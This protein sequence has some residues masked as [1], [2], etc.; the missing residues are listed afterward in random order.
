MSLSSYPSS[1]LSVQPP[2]SGGA[3]FS[4][5]SLF[6]VELPPDFP[7]SELPKCEV[8]GA[9][10][11]SKAALVTPESSYLLTKVESSNAFVVVP[12]SSAPGEEGGDGEDAENQPEP[13]RMKSSICPSFHY[14]LTP[15]RLDICELQRILSESVYEGDAE[16]VSEKSSRRKTEAELSILLQASDKELKEALIKVEAF[17]DEAGRYTLVSEEL[18]SD[19]FDEILAVISANDLDLSKIVL[20]NLLGSVTGDISTEKAVVEHCLRMNSS[21]LGGGAFK[22]DV[23]KVAHFKARKILSKRSEP[24]PVKQFMQQWSAEMPHQCTSYSPPFSL[25]ADLCLSSHDPKVG[26]DVLAY[27]PA[28]SLPRDPESRFRKL[29]EV[30][31]CWKEEDIG[32]FLK[33]IL[34]EGEKEVQLLLKHALMK[35]KGE[36]I[37]KPLL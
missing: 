35:S 1:L 23:E 34:K 11:S 25:V 20:S 24:Y 27:F 26:D 13:K 36:W 16:E 7:V 3:D 5:P 33:E 8:V 30:R 17:K 31:E 14:E 18:M 9:S 10:A 28:S 6:L 4:D 15:H 29:F 32:P 12:P 21:D 2:P 37:A 22:V 19:A